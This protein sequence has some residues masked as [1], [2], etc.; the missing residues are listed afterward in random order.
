MNDLV[1]P[2]EIAQVGEFKGVYNMALNEF[3]DWFQQAPR[4]RASPRLP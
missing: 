2:Q 4:G 3:L 1:A